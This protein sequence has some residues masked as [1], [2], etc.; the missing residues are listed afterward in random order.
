MRMPKVLNAA[1]RE[2]IEECIRQRKY[3]KELFDAGVGDYVGFIRGE[4][5]IIDETLNKLGIQEESL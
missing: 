1:D 2:T 4:K 3:N 5:S